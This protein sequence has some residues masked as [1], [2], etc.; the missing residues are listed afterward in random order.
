M[1]NQLNITGRKVGVEHDPLIIADI[2]INHNGSLSTAKDMV[3]TAIAAGVDVIKHQTH[4][5]TDE[6]TKEAK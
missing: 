2:G 4:I 1:N 3:D 6:M 5:V